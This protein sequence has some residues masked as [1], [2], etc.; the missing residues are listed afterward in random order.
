[1]QR[2]PT[3]L[4]Q[5]IGEHSSRQQNS[6]DIGGRTGEQLYRN[7]PTLNNVELPNVADLDKL[8]LQGRLSHCFR[9]LAV[10]DDH[11][12]ATDFGSRWEIDEIN[13]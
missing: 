3:A 10:A 13:F 1:M 9:D 7:L 2:K 8:L 5:Q 12:R 4:P 6:D 11:V